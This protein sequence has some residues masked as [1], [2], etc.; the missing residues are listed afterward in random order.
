[1]C[2]GRIYNQTLRTRHAL[3]IRYNIRSSRH[4]AE[5]V[6][7]LK[8]SV[9]D[10][11]NFS[12]LPLTSDLV[13]PPPPLLPLLLSGARN[14]RDP[15]ATIIHVALKKSP[16]CLSVYTRLQAAAGLL[17]QETGP[18]VHERCSCC[19]S[20]GSNCCYHEIFDSLL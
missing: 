10:K 5:H 3:C 17:D 9:S 11:Q 7:V 1:M 2:V 8:Y 4:R 14:T 19:C 15:L 12:E 16:A 18:N 6:P 13:L 20:M